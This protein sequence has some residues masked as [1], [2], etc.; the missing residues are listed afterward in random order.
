V[1]RKRQENGKRSR[2]RRPKNGVPQGSILVPFSSTPTSLTCQPPSPESM[3]MLT[4]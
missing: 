4:I 1:L 2:L 3:H